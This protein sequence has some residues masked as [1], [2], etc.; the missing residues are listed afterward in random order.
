ML[1]IFQLFYLAPVYSRLHRPTSAALVLLISAVESGDRCLLTLRLLLFE[2]TDGTRTLT[3]EIAQ[4]FT[5]LFTPELPWDASISCV[6]QNGHYEVS[7][8]PSFAPRDGELELMRIRPP[9]E[10]RTPDHCHAPRPCH[11]GRDR[12]CHRFALSTVLRPRW[13]SVP[14]TH[15]PEPESRLYNCR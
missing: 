7:C 6:G 3:D 5:W 13:A 12:G 9:A 4:R 1:F 11:R 8:A 2:V 10:T 14:K 15:Q